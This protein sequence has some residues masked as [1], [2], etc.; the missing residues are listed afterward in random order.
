[1]Y[2]DE[3]KNK[4]LLESRQSSM[5][6]RIAPRL[7]NHSAIYEE[8]LQKDLCAIDDKD[9][10]LEILASITGGKIAITSKYRNLIVDYV[11]WCRD[12]NYSG[13]SDL[14]EE[15]TD[16]D[17]VER[18][19]SECMVADPSGLQK[20][21]N[22]VFREET[23]NFVDNTARCYFWLA[24]A[25]VPYLEAS[26]VTVAD[27]DLDIIDGEFI[28]RNNGVSYSIPSIGFEAVKKCAEL[29]AFVIETESPRKEGRFTYITPRK[30]GNLLLRGAE[31]KRGKQSKEDKRDPILAAVQKLIYLTAKKRG[32]KIMYYSDI[33]LS[34]FFC[35]LYEQEKREQMADQKPN[36]T[37]AFREF[38]LK[39]SDKKNIRSQSYY[40]KKYYEIWKKFFKNNF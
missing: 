27:V 15:I 5:Q 32:R 17:I 20:Y 33:R 26:K 8:K 38:E 39:S 29:N 36:F 3:W 16:E 34:G 18:R 35:R 23:E 19:I 28:V 7:F 2:N 25:G 37:Q 22:N 10:L 6:N 13:V 11:K 40:T 14:I 12:E 4:F 24:F 9:I 30:E 1:M 31:P 21:L